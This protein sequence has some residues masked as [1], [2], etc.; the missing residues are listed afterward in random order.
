MSKTIYLGETAD[1]THIY[2]DISLTAAGAPLTMTDHTEGTAP[3]VAI[4]F[5][6]LSRQGNPRT[7]PDRVH[8]SG[9]QI[10]E[11]ERV[12][13]HRARALDADTLALIERAWR[14]D[15]LNH[16]HTECDHMTPEMLD[17]SPE[18]IAAYLAEHPTKPSYSALQ[19]Y[20]LDR[21]VCP[22]TGY[23]YGH[24][25]LAKQPNAADYAALT[26]LIAE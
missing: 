24:A 2:A 10:R 19:H 16:M 22:V 11:A 13:V 26:V 8:I 12:I 23:R 4:S 7:A 1:K 20:R 15:H 5:T 9:G 6:E 25:W 18:V 17:P 14:D 21:V 3:E